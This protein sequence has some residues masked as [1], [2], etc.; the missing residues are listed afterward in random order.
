MLRVLG[1]IAIFCAVVGVLYYA[2]VA[3]TQVSC[4]VCIDFGG[5]S[6]CRTSAGRDR[7]E[8][9]QGASNL[10]CA[11]LSSGVTEGLRCGRT[12]PR[13]VHCSD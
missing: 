4:E 13:S 6:E 1:G 12:P 10:A 2:T 11:V 3:E 8:A 7:D 5:R 9:I